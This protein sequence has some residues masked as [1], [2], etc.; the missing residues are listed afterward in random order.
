MAKLLFEPVYSALGTTA[1]VSAVYYRKAMS[2]KLFC[3]PQTPFHEPSL[4]TGYKSVLKLVTLL[5]LLTGLYLSFRIQRAYNQ[6]MN[7]DMHMGH[8]Q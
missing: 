6:N 1:G 5:A 2:L 4:R 7:C 3:F 8:T